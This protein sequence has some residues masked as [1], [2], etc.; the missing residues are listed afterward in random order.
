[1]EFEGQITYLRNECV[2][3][4]RTK[5]RFGGLSNMAAGYPLSINGINIP[6]SEALYQA[7]RFPHKSEIQ[8]VIIGQRSPMTAKMK[9]KPYRKDTRPDWD[10]VRVDIMWWCLRVK[11]AQHWEK[12]GDLLLSTGNNP[13]IEESYKDQ[14]WGAKPVSEE[15]LIGLNVLGQLLTNLRELLKRLDADKLQYVSPLTLSQ[16]LLIDKPIGAIESGNHKYD[17]STFSVKETMYDLFASD[18]NVVP[19]TRKDV[20][21]LL[22]VDKHSASFSEGYIPYASLAPENTCV[23][24]SLDFI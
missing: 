10:Q 6:T 15:K 4:M 5:E 20:R 7:C 16:F 9:S 2:L 11:L 24:L 13:I 8:K 18:R 22:D 21:S 23:Q 3:F 19:S 17:T 1:M 14:F 12:F